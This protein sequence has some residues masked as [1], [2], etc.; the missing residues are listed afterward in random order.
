[1]LARIRII[2][3]ALIILGS[4]ANFAQNDWGNTLI[5][6]CEGFICLMFF[7]EGFVHL[8][9]RIKIGKNYQEGS[10]YEH[11]LLGLFFLSFVFRI[12]W[13]PGGNLLVIISALFLIPFYIIQMVSFY[14]NNKSKG[15]LLVTLLTIGSFTTLVLGISLVFKIMHWPWATNLYFVGLGFT[16]IMIIGSAKWNFDYDNNKINILSALGLLKNNI[17]LLYFLSFIITTFGIL[18]SSG[19]GP[20]F[21][22]EKMPASVEK[23]INKKEKGSTAKADEIKENYYNFIWNCEKNG[24]L[25]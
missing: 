9:K 16:I 5:G 14:R 23:E 18:S 21:Y 15:Q 17:I 13:W 25:E 7:I 22:S 20:K 12:M 2:F 11:L 8:R 24:F 19:F 10:A 6:W 4:F 3:F 1:M